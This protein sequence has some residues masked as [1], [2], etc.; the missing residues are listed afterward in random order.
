MHL[1]RRA[2]YGSSRHTPALR[3]DGSWGTLTIGVSWPCWIADPPWIPSLWPAPLTAAKPIEPIKPS[4]RPP[5][6][7]SPGSG[8]GIDIDD[9]IN[10]TA[11]PASSGTPAPSAPQPTSAAAQHMAIAIANDRS[12]DTYH[13]GNFSVSCTALHIRRQHTEIIP[14]AAN[15]DIDT[16]FAGLELALPT[17]QAFAG[18][19]DDVHYHR[20]L[21][22]GTRDQCIA[23]NGTHPAPHTY[24]IAECLKNH[25]W[26]IRHTRATDSCPGRIWWHDAR[27]EHYLQP[28]LEEPRGDAHFAQRM[29]VMQHRSAFL[30]PDALTSTSE[31][32]TYLADEGLRGRLMAA[33]HKIL[34]W[35]LQGVELYLAWI[36]CHPQ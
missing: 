7:E 21:V 25:A 30:K 17:G 23:C 27:L 36:H 31:P 13:V 28:L 18:I 19:N 14:A 22:Q 3:T 5:P 10:A 9:P 6:P 24:E 32:Y 26:T 29:L 35:M 20:Y 8:G 1:C 16:A 15:V 33:P 34:A 12:H 11:A 2:L 4:K